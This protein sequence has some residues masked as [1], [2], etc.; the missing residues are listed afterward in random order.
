MGFN[1]HLS[2]R[3]H[4]SCRT[5]LAEAISVSINIYKLVI[6]WVRVCLC[7]NRTKGVLSDR[8]TKSEHGVGWCGS[9]HVIPGFSFMFFCQKE[10]SGFLACNSFYVHLRN[11]GVAVLRFCILYKTWV[12]HSSTV[13][14]PSWVAWSTGAPVSPGARE[15]EL[16]PATNGS[17]EVGRAKRTSR[18]SKRTEYARSKTLLRTITPPK[19]EEVF[20]IQM[21]RGDDPKKES[22]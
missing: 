16:R 6:V 13:H 9:H 18:G 5:R 12:A 15:I 3:P 10:L 4:S 1:T 19:L 20:S 22:T 7:S 8:N 21:G 11:L 17:I 14:T 2:Q